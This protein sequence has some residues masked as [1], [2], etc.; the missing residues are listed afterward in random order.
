MNLKEHMHMS[1]QSERDKQIWT[2]KDMCKAGVI[3]A[4][5]GAIIAALWMI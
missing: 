5:F 1:L 3:G 4:F 2:D